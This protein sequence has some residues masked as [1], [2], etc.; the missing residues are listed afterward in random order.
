M[1]ELM[2]VKT[3]MVEPGMIIGRDIY[4]MAG[5]LIA[6]KGTRLSDR[7]ITR[8]KF[9]SVE[10]VMIVTPEALRKQAPKK[11][12]IQ[13]KPFVIPEAS[14]VEKV[15]ASSDYKNFTKT[16][17]TSF[18]SC[19][20][21]INNV[22]EN[23]APLNTESLLEQVSNIMSTCKNPS[24]LL[25]MLMGIRDLD[26]A[27]YVHSMNVALICN[28]FAHWLKFDEKETK[29]LTLAG[30][31]HDIGKM[32]IPQEIIKKPGKLSDEEYRIIQQH[33][34]L[35]YELLKAQNANYHICMAALMHHERCDGHGYPNGYTT[36]KIDSYA[37]IVSIADVFD[38]LTAART[39]RGPICPLEVIGVF[40]TDGLNV[41]DPKYLMV[42]LDQIMYS[43]LNYTVE[44]SNGEIGR[45]VMMQRN[46]LSKPVI[47]LSDDR[48]IDLR[49]DPTISIVG[50]V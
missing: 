28:L 2:K 24:S 46:T 9:Y 8:L 40:Q 39:Y 30:L 10:E 15:K 38:A 48:F 32:M 33:P 37:K 36:K 4:S 20:E 5:N 23:K 31:L 43:Y 19:K 18:V 45:I 47:A 21:Q 25:D 22:I 12:V 29:V 50:I 44:L 26:D 11:S 17:Y 13:K 35:G 41:Y 14:Y 16:F 42:F 7:M 3:S 6:G 27:T 1:D 49:E 34:V